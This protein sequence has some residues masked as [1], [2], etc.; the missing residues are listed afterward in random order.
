MKKIKAL[1]LDKSIFLNGCVKTTEDIKNSLI[2]I[3]LDTDE[4]GDAT[5]DSVY[6]ALE[7]KRVNAFDWTATTGE[8]ISVYCDDEALFKSGLTLGTTLIGADEPVLG[9]LLFT[10]IPDCEGNM[11]DIPLSVNSIDQLVQSLSIYQI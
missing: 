2:P 6:K 3:E 1:L 9:S 5:L 7:I 11:Q 10:G 8:N 4:D